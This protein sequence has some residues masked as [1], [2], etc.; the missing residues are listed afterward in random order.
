MAAAQT[1]SDPAPQGGEFQI[2]PY[3]APLLP[4]FKTLQ[5][6][7]S[8][9]GH[10]DSEAVGVMAGGLHHQAASDAL[11]QLGG[12]LDTAKAGL[13]PGGTF[14]FSLMG[15]KTNGNL[16]AQTG[17]VQTT[18]NDWAPNFLRLYQFSYAQDL[19]AGFVRAG[20][21]DVNYY[22]ASVGLAGQLLNASFGPVP[23]L[24]SNADMPPFHTQAWG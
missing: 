15:V 18:S 13:W 17:A 19:G 3:N 24:T 11:L 8:F 23:T 1:L 14:D 4:P 7:L 21:M 6:G 16:P 5:N 2:A 10:L 22:F 20:I 9:S 12:S